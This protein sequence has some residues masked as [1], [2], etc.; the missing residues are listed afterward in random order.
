MLSGK[1]AWDEM[2]ENALG[3]TQGSKGGARAVVGHLKRL[4]EKLPSQQAPKIHL[5][6][7]SAG[8]IFHA[9]L[10]TALT[11]AGIEIES[12]TLWAP[13][14]TIELFKQHYAPAIKKK[15]IKRFALFTLSDKAEQDDHCANIYHKS[16]LYL[17][18]H[19]FED[20]PRIPL[21]RGGVPILG[22]EKYVR[23]DV[24]LMSLFKSD[25]ASW[26][27]APNAKSLGSADASTSLQHG[28]FDDDDATVRATLRR[29]LGDGVS[30]GAAI[31]FQRSAASLRDSRVK[32]DRAAGF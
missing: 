19:S 8:S 6:G 27:I 14:C 13:A 21:Y 22:M 7:H 30:K 4:L 15:R 10:V 2:K 3:A 31:K 1:A 16:L 23:Q 9:P 18:S 29:I 25:A 20:E 12:C 11:E 5:V 17:V 26:V 32:A 28:S 24:E